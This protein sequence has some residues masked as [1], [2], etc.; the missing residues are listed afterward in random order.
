MDDTAGDLQS[1]V[2]RAAGYLRMLSEQDAGEP[3]APG[4][5]SRRQIIGH[6]IDS[7][8]NNHQR[9]VRAQFQDHLE[10]VGYQQDD[11]V[12]VQRYQTAPWTE[13]VDLWELFNLH[14]ARVIDAVPDGI[15]TR[16]CSRHNLDAVAWE[17]PSADATVTLAFFMRDYLNHLKYH[18]RQIDESLASMP[19]RQLAADR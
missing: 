4:K 15:R 3:I 2:S 18:L 1:T 12:A 14:L 13:L 10:F 8:S 9:F 11:W 6:L 5:W 19:V 7:A 16:S 17:Q